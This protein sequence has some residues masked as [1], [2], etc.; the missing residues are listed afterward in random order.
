M[1]SFVKT[2]VQKLLAMA[3]IAVNGDRPWDIRVHDER[4]YARIAKNGSLGLGEA[5]V[6]RWWECDRL[7][8][9][10]ERIFL[11]KLNKKVKGW[12]I[13]A[14]LAHMVWNRQS[15]RRS[16][17]VGEKHYD[18]GNT[19]YCVML[20]KSMTYTCAYWKNAQTLDQAQEAKLDII[21]RKLNLRAGQKVLDIGCG[22]GS[23]A[24]FA[25]LRYGVSVVGITIS[26]E[27]AVLARELCAGLPVE[28]RIQDYREVSEPFDHIVSIGMFEHVGYKN[29]RTFMHIAN[30][31]LKDAGLFLLHTMGSNESNQ[32]TDPWIDKYIFPNGM[33]P[34]IHQIGCAIE[35][36][37]VMEDWHNF[38]AD[39][40][41]TLMAW[42]KNFEGSWKKLRS[43][44]N[45]RFRRVWNYYLLSCAG[46][47]RARNIELWQIVLSKKGVPGGYHSV[48]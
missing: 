23:F 3:D 19:L 20:G 4:L 18:I 26:K 13:F 32:H 5:Y 41:K 36:I 47:F 9:F 46:A 11:A 6:D 39:Y 7:D 16:V 38:G 31:C 37:F 34:S 48:R 29:Y 2:N 35:G 43:S 1:S 22:W 44:Y 33:I 42:H 24:K 30:R 25:A 17:I 21:C 14:T 15:S 28:I 27:Q 40:D 45:E 10:F 12:S 8:Q